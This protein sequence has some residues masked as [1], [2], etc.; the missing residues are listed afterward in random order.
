[1]IKLK[2]MLSEGYA[3][4]RKPG[5]KL[6]T[7]EDV[8][9]IHEQEQESQWSRFKKHVYDSPL[10]KNEPNEGDNEEF[11]QLYQEEIREQRINDIQRAIELV[12]EAQS[13][14]DNAISG[15]PREGNY[16]AYGKY[17]FSTLL[18]NGNPN[19]SSLFTL[20]DEMP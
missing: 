3:W 2:K 11:E 1:M 7:L 9:K 5:G 4:E 15:T 8:K 16:Q 6:P 12:E 13:L 10:V 18:G 17:G 14:V 19:D 20:I